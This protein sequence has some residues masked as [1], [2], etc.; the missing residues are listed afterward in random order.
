MTWTFHDKH[1]EANP[2]CGCKA[3]WRHYQYKGSRTVLSGLE[4]L[5]VTQ[6]L[7][8]LD[9]SR[10]LISWA[11]RIDV[12]GARRLATE[13][14]MRCTRKGCSRWLVPLPFTDGEGYGLCEG[15]HGERA[16]GSQLRPYHIPD[17]GWK[18]QRDIKLA[19]L[20]HD[21]V[22]KEAQFRGT[23]I[24]SI[25]EAWV[26]DGKLPTFGDYPVA[27]HG[28]IRAY[29]KFLTSGRFDGFEWAER[30]VGSVRY[31][32]AGTCDTVAIVTAKDGA[33][34]RLDFKTSK[35]VYPDSNYR[36]LGAYE[37]GDRECG[38]EPT[39]RQGIVRLG[40]DGEV[41]V[42]YLDEGGLSCEWWYNAFLSTLDVCR[43][44]RA[45]NKAYPRRGR[46]A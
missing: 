30:I 14:W 40:A 19:Q 20:D 45:I 10:P 32:Y 11:T 25:H 21:T 29:A 24:H 3:H 37:G 23:T 15:D 27:W 1:G 2:N 38:G 44:Q 46:K 34:E 33:R 13:D 7:G 6:A 4:I 9:K 42:R 8:V 31:G 5:S 41:E 35:R 18:L 39:D 28:Y 43:D 17:E 12:D 36:Q 22:V 16:C 26:K